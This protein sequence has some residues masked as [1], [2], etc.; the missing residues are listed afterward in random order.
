MAFGICYEYGITPLRTHNTLPLPAQVHGYGLGEIG[1]LGSWFSKALKPIKK[2]AKVVLRVATAPIKAT[3]RLL[4]G[5]IKGAA[6]FVVAPWAASEA[7]RGRILRRAGGVVTGAATGFF[8]GGGIV[9]AVAGGITGGLSAKKG[10]KGI[11]GYAG[12]ALKSAAVAGA[13]SIATGAFAQAGFAKGFISQQ[14]AQKAI[15]ASGKLGMVGTGFVAGAPIG[16]AMQLAPVTKAIA[17]GASTVYGVGAKAV[18]AGM[19]MLGLMKKPAVPG[20]E[21]MQAGFDTPESFMDTIRQTQTL[22]PSTAGMRADVP[23][24]YGGA[25]QW[26]AGSVPLPTG[27]GI[28]GQYPSQYDAEGAGILGGDNIKNILLIGGLA[29]LVL[30][31]V[32]TK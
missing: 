2:V 28:P 25:E 5:D 8:T 22:I 16:A 19:S 7:T 20:T 18:G 3:G 12:V 17:G 1:D 32:K 10:V 27:A 6:G 30:G 9:G 14:A 26:G 13:A 31:F 29:I 21:E 11:K 24:G 23:A 15:L 4:K